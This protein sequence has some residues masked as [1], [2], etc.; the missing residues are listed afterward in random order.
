MNRTDFCVLFGWLEGGGKK[1]DEAD[2]WKRLIENIW[3]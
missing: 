3:K 2:E 1:D